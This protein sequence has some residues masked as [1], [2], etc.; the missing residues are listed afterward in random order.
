MIKH[1]AL[2]K[3]RSDVP[4]ADLIDRYEREHVPLVRSL[5]PFFSDYRRNYVADHP[6]VPR[7]RDQRDPRQPDFDV[8]TQLWYQD[9]KQLIALGQALGDP[10]IEAA[11]LESEA[12]L[13]DQST[14]TILECDEYATPAAYLQP[15]RAG[16]SGRPRIKLMGLICKKAGMT[17]EAFIDRYENGH[18]PLALSVLTKDGMPTFAEYCRTYP[19][20][21]PRFAMASEKLSPSAPT[22]DVIT[23]AWFWTEADF[24]HFLAQRADPNVDAALS[25]D[26]A[27]VFDRA[28][29]T[30]YFLDERI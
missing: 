27:E 2:M 1:V 10:A 25:R 12:R 21:A 11:I 8:A 28:S 5:L 13:F 4:R 14:M 22:I 24:Q 19:V 15:R 18:C 26:E 20:A 6:M 23:E 17:R 3:F 16:Y 30:M 7:G 9:P 29:I